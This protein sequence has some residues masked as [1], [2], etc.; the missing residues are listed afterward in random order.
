[1]IRR[2][3]LTAAVVFLVLAGNV[4]APASSTA[5]RE[6]APHVWEDVRRVVAIGDLHGNDRK[7][8]QLMIGSGL[9]DPNMTWAGGE[10]H[11]V[12]TGDFLDRGVGDRPMM[13]HL[14]RLQ[15]ES[16]AAG[17]RVHVLLGNHEV[18]NL[19]RDNRYVNEETYDSFKPD[20]TKQDRHRAWKAFSAADRTTARGAALQSFNRS[21]PPG[22]FGRQKSFEP[23]GEYGAWLLEQPVIVKINGVV[24]LHGGLS[25]E[26]AALGIEGINDTVATQLTRHLEGRRILEVEGI[27]TPVMD[28]TDIGSV[29]LALLERTR[30]PSNEARAAAKSMLEAADNPILRTRGP[31]WYRGNSFEDERIEGLTVE[32]SLELVAA[33]AMVIAHSPTRGD[34]ITS[35][36]HGR[37]FRID[38]GIGKSDRPQA[39]VV[40]GEGVF[41][42]NPATGELTRP[43][44]EL[45]PGT[46]YRPSAGEIPEA[47]LRDFL[48]ESEVIESRELGRGGTRPRLVVLQRDGTTRR[49]VFKTVQVGQGAEGADRYQHEIAAY[50]LDR[51]LGL[52]MVPVTVAREIDD[53]VGSLQ[54]W[55]ERA[56][57]QQA[58][59]NYDLSLYTSEVTD[60][61]LELSQL[62]DALIGNDYRSPTDILMPLKG[63][64]LRL[65]DHS[66]AFSISPELDWARE[67]V[68]I[69][70]SLAAA[71]SALDRASLSANLGDLIDASQIDALLARRDKI[72]ALI[73]VV[74]PDVPAL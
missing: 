30:G 19:F 60:R 33:R 72:L 29:G 43:V 68:P 7:F 10:D 24:Y 46:H 13:D 38:H 73:E 69:A 4:S 66:R 31:L 14:R 59:L 42:L 12:V 61:E 54:W 18:M 11:L 17:G 15:A 23:E 70:P 16:L 37:L 58:A 67:T 20:E 40:E 21:F 22:Y 27:V 56:I 47:L 49:A 39:L 6:V 71:L 25:E 45:P 2:E 53:Q 52:G 51:S 28:L 74:Q 64:R 5:A 62:F 26:F 50:R 35:R 57:D 34:Q 63:G 32:R 48:S 55:I 41:V 9:V 3:R 65:I 36:F 44:R 8:S 1:M